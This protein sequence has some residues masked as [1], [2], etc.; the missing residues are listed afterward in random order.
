MT[1]KYYWSSFIRK[2]GSLTDPYVMIPGLYSW[3]GS[4]SRPNSSCAFPIWN[5]ATNIA[6]VMNIELSAILFPGQN[7]CV[8]R[9]SYNAVVVSRETLTSGRNRKRAHKDQA[10]A[11]LLGIVQASQIL[12]P[13]KELDH[14]IFPYNLYKPPLT[15]DIRYTHQQ[16]GII[17]EPFGIL[18]PA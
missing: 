5:V 12:D 4:M 10:P 15:P 14:A 16:F 17:T 1:M 2:T 7:L 8:M 18:Y 11:R 13:C 3:S 6:I 9:Q